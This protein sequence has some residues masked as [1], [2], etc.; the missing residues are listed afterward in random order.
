MLQVLRHLRKLPCLVSL[1]GPE[2][3]SP[4]TSSV[5]FSTHNY[6]VVET[7]P[8]ANYTS[9]KQIY[10]YHVL[11]ESLSNLSGLLVIILITW[12]GKSRFK[13][14]FSSQPSSVY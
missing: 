4:G 9:A 8:V 14:I 7:S 6:S 2:P 3:C 13:D 12:H 10:H 5:V 11:V 1:E